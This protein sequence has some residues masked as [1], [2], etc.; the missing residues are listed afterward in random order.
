MKERFLE[1][2]GQIPEIEKLFYR[3]PSTPGVMSS[4]ELVIYDKP[5]FSFW[6]QE[7]R[8]EVQRII[9]LSDDT[10]AKDTLKALTNGFN[11]W[12][13][14]RKFND[15]KG[16]L[17]AMERN[18]D[19]YY[20]PAGINTAADKPVKI[21]ISH[22]SRD[23]EQVARLVGLF[24]DMSL[25]QTQVF[26]SSLPGYGI[27]NDKDIFDYLR[28]LFQQFQLH[29]VIVHSSNY[30]ASPVCLNEMGAAWVLRT[31][32]T[33]F[34][35]PGFEFDS[36]KGVVNGRTISIKLDGEKTEVKDRLNQLYDTVVDEFGLTKKA[37][38]IWEQ[39]RD[40]FIQAINDIPHDDETSSS[41]VDEND[42]EKD[43][44]GLLYRKSEK[45][46]GKDIVYCPTCY[47]KYHQ[48]YMVTHG[49][50]RRDLFCTNCKAH[51]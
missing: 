20:S 34:L 8:L 40:T 18:V 23:K 45:E 27:P 48:L 31:N 21:F 46:A 25:D 17:L 11:G 32:C 41:S 12:S 15:I 26:C 2:V 16:R 37:A 5:E 24:D 35:L 22:A 30:Y 3:S 29:V 6:L 7:V 13:D 49:S 4:A 19:Q 1:L 50:M 14:Q 44:H 9:D 28:E 10:F 43:S 51:F 38:I 47:T 33:S 39:K 42:M 36:M